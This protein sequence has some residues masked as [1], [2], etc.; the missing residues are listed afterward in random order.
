M[1]SIR[2]TPLALLAATAGALGTTTAL[3][4]LADDIGIE[5]VVV[6]ATRRQESLQDVPLAVSALSGETLNKQGVFET[7]DLH[8]IA[9]NMQVSSPYGTQQPNFSIRG[10]GVGTEYNANAASP[11]GV[12]VDE[13]YQTFRASHG[14][15]LY[16][17]EQVE[18]VRGP[19]GTLFGR[20]TTGGTINFITRKP[21]LEGTKGYLSAG[22]GNYDRTSFEGAVEFTPVTDSLGIRLA[23]TYVETD[24]YIENKLPAGPSTAAFGGASGLN[25]NTG[26]DPEGHEN[27]GVRGTIRF[28]PTD[29]IDLTLKAYAAE[30]EGGQ[31]PPLPTGS[32]KSSDVIDYTNPNFLL[33]AFFQ[34]F[35]ALAPGALP[36]SYSQSANGLDIREVELDSVGDAVTKAEGFV[37]TADIGIND[38]TNIVALVGFD[39]GDYEQLPTTDCDA[40]PLALCTIGYDSEFDA[41]NVDVRLNYEGDRFNFIIGAFYGEDSLESDNRPNFFN[42]TRD[43]NAALGLPPTYFNPGGAFNGAGLSPASLPTGVNAVQSFEQDRQSWAVYAE[44]NYDL[45]EEFTLTIGLRYSDDELEYSNGL[46]TYF[47]DAG[48]ARLITVS[49]YRAGGVFAPYFLED[50]LDEAGNVVIPAAIVNPGPTP[51]GHELEDGSDDVSGRVIL[52]WKPSDELMVYASFSRGYRAG[53][54]NGLA[55]GTA[56]QVYFVP[57][58]E[59]DAYEIGFKSRFA[60]N[61]VQ[62]NAAAFFYDYD[63]Q[64]G[65]V[66]DATAT[67]NLISLDGEISG[68]EMELQWLAT[69]NL[70]FNVAAGWLD[71]EYDDGSPCAPGSLTG[72]FP[73]QRGNCLLSSGGE[74][75]VGGNPYPFASEFTFNAGFDWDIAQ[76]G[77]GML[78][79]HVDANFTDDFNYD[80]FGDYT[81]GPLPTVATGKFV[82]GSEDYWVYNARLTWEAE[83]LSVSVWGKN[84]GDEEYYPYGISIENL[85]AN[86]YR[87]IGP[88]RTYG[89]ELRYNF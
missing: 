78:Q 37:L 5:E 36:T 11:V 66:V 35:A 61:R 53:T 77:E 39:S 41:F 54:I 9:P 1:K 23:G 50:V 85:F 32:S 8:R 46:T 44:G 12:Y 38:R 87:I 18:V 27:W 64:Q 69:S 51:R 15:Q 19:Q 45:T 29:N 89:L 88:P 42:F 40:T 55:Y 22:Y 71:S 14:Q 60:D 3:P 58:E 52:D 2:I 7:T 56:N 81:D 86:G 83:N 24:S 59:V 6:T 76:I 63:G 65:Q 21:E 70:T 4:A 30:S 17:L 13:V 31:A 28:V 16:D 82:D 80:P 20:N 49:D 74:V 73:G 72:V 34:G 67:A 57:P 84:L 33:G 43:V 26:I 10:V 48:V 62:L 25:R 75:D 79:L 68:V 47:D